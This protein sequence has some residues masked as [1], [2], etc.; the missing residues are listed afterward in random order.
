MCA[1]G[2]DDTA[3]HLEEQWIVEEMAEP[4]D[5]VADRRLGHVERRSR[6]GDIA[7]RHDR[8]ENPEQIQIKIAKHVLSLQ[9]M[10]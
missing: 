5:G 10:N 2:R 1:G 4:I 9:M 3:M 7:L 6:L 8:I